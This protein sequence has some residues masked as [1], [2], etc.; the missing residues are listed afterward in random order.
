MEETNKIVINPNGPYR[1]KLL[2]KGIDCFVQIKNINETEF[3]IRVK[4]DKKLNEPDLQGLMKYL[5][6]EGFTNQA[7]K[8]NLFW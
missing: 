1:V 6:T 5:D 7:I 8:H 4:T 3:D 2:Y